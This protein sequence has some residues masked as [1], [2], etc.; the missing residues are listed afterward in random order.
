M[1]AFTGRQFAI[2]EVYRAGYAQEFL[3]HGDS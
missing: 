2:D 3:R 1:P